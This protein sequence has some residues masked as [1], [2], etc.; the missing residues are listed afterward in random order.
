MLKAFSFLFFYNLISHLWTWN[1]KSF[2]LHFAREEVVSRLGK[3]FYP[4]SSL[5]KLGMQAF[6]IQQMIQKSNTLVYTEV[7]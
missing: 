4:F 3:I 5:F 6:L 2:L 1:I 7:F